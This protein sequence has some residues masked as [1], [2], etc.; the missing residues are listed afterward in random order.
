MGLH[1]DKMRVDKAPRP[2][3]TSETGKECGKTKEATTAVGKILFSW[4]SIS[5]KIAT[6][7]MMI[8]T[9]QKMDNRHNSASFLIICSA[10]AAGIG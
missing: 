7:C 6:C 9:S 8:N 10:A 3:K 1:G 2:C 5:R 4:E